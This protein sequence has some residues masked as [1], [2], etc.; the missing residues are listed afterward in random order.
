MKLCSGKSDAL[1]DEI[2]QASRT[3]SRRQFDMQSGAREG[4]GKRTRKKLMLGHE[5][6]EQFLL[7]LVTFLSS[8]RYTTVK[9]IRI[10]RAT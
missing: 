7:V 5:R 3:H 6:K 8:N 9:H 4:R 1:R 10:D 2:S